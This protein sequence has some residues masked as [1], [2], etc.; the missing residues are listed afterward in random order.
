MAKSEEHE[1]HGPTCD[2]GLLVDRPT[3]LLDTATLARHLGVSKSYL[4]AARHRAPEGKAPS[5]WRPPLGQIGSADVWDWATAEE[6][7][8]A[9][10]DK[11]TAPPR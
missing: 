2:C 7:R 10:E 6:M 9:R 8:I 5:W 11:V 4:F 3:R 1:A